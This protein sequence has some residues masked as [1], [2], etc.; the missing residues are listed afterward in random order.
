MLNNSK[1]SPALVESDLLGIDLDTVR[2]LGNGIE[3]S[4]VPTIENI[5][6]QWTG[7]GAGTKYG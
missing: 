6:A 2:G 3:R 1:C 7:S 4:T 5:H